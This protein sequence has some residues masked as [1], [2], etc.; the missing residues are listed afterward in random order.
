L[1]RTDP[2]FLAWRVGLEERTGRALQER[3]R[4]LAF[5]SVERR[6]V[7]LLR[8]YAGHVGVESAEGIRLEARLSERSLAADLAVSRRA[9]HE[10]LQRLRDQ[11]CIAK[12]SGRYWLAGASRPSTA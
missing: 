3:L 7:G 11:Q 9:V 10:A 4:A 6:V 12:R 2:A 1:S 5:E 8:E